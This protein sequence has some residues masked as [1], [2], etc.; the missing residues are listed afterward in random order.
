MNK[1][2]FVRRQSQSETENRVPSASSGKLHALV[3][4]AGI[5]GLVAA[6]A[7]LKRGIDCDVY[8]QAP[9]L[10]EVGAGL[11]LSANGTRVLFDMG[12]EE[13]L[14]EASI[15]CTERV[16]RHWKSGSTWWLYKR[17]GEGR[18]PNTPY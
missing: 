8:E 16:I 17:E 18:S 13:P 9:E 1:V 2:Y 10:R 11:W 15:E 7:L 4:G 5:G 14:R 3:A 6:L 12:L